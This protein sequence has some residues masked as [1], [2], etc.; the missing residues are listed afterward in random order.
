[1]VFSFVAPQSGQVNVTLKGPFEKAIYVKLGQCSNQP[2]QCVR[3]TNF[4][5][6]STS[7]TAAKGE[8]YFVYIDS[9]HDDEWGGFNLSISY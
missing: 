2:I 1:M 6:A 3:H 4:D 9:T 8:T 5:T 7:F